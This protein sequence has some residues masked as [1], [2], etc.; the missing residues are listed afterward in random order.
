MISLQYRLRNDIDLVSEPVNKILS[1]MWPIKIC[2]NLLQ[3]V[4]N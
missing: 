4:M 3:E 2:M 1:I